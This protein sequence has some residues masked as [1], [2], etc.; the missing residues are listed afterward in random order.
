M[1][2]ARPPR[3]KRD[4]R[5]GILESMLALLGAI[6]GD[7][8]KV[9]SSRC[10]SVRH[11][12]ATCQRCV[13]SCT[14]GALGREGNQLA[15]HPELCIG[16][17]TCAAAC[18]TSAIETASLTDEALTQAIRTSV[19]ATKGHPVF[20]CEKAIA[21]YRDQLDPE[22]LG[23]E[24][25]ELRCLGRLDESAFAGLAAYRSFDA[26]LVCGD[27]DT[28]PQ[29]P[30]GRQV[31]EVAASSQKLV[32][33]FGSTMQVSITQQMPER[34]L[35][36]PKGA[37]GRRASAPR[38][39]EGSPATASAAMDRRQVF[40]S[41]KEALTSQ[42]AVLAAE[43]LG[44]AGQ[45]PAE[46]PLRQQLG[47]INEEGT[48]PQFVPSRRTRLYNYLNHIGT[49]TVDEVT[50]RT[51]GTISIDGDTCRQC[52][53]C[54]TFCPTGALRRLNSGV[55]PALNSEVGEYSHTA[56][57]KLARDI[58]ERAAAEYGLLHRPAACVRCRACEQICPVGAITVSDTVPLKEFMGKQA[59]VYRMTP[60]T[61]QPNKP[62]S[63]YMKIHEV[64]GSDLEMCM[65]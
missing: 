28:C 36:A 30:G 20:A 31:R 53:M 48:L 24:V 44:I 32:E 17:G 37:F 13:D 14:T 56:P 16:C 29:A 59:V 9:D 21:R 39:K 65:F 52:R 34:C 38:A 10:I 43:E 7:A 6:E 63:M 35:G 8:V 18:P 41:A 54:A 19:K 42:A 62:D 47:K 61:W 40:A 46:A 60:P 22:Q 2:A 49:P 23:R 25:C 58:P 33:A 5:M 27:C 51:I 50:S 45:G 12:R 11:Q 3:R 55:Q 15:V 4:K 64:L 57:N 26:T 1:G